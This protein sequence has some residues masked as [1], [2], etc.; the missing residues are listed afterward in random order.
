MQRDE[1]MI[2]TK[3]VSYFAAAM[4]NYKKGF[5][6]F[7]AVLIAAMMIQPFISMFGPKMMID[8]IVRKAVIINI[9]KIA[10]VMILADFAVKLITTFINEELDK[11]YYTGLDRHLEAAVGKKSME[12]KFETTENKET[13]D[14]LADARTGID[15]GYSGGSKGLFNSLAILIVNSVVLMLSVFVVCRYSFIPL[16]LVVVNVSLNAFFESRLNTIKIEQIQQLAVTDRA[17]HYLLHGLSD[18]RYGKDIRL[19]NAKDMM[20]GRVDEFN[21]KQSEINKTQAKKAQKYLTGSKINQAVT[22]SLT[23]LLLAMMVAEKKI[24][25]GDFTM[26]VAAVTTIVSAINL[27]LKQILELKKF[28]GYSDKF[29]RYVEGNVYEEK[30]D[31]KTD[32]A[33]GIEIEFKNVY[34]KYPGSMEYALKNINAVIRSGERW[35]VVGLNGAGK[36]TFIKLICR[37]Y[38]C[39]KGEILLNGVNIMDYEYSSYMKT[40]SAVF[41]DFC[42]L[43][44]SIKENIICDRPDKAEDSELTSLLEEVG[45][46][47]KVDSLPQGLMTPVFRYYDQSGFEPSGGEQQKIAMARALYKDAPVLILDEPT[48]ALDP[49]AEREIYE[50]FNS[51]VKNKTAIFI[52]HRLASCR[53]CDKLLVFKD[54]EIVERGTHQSLLKLKDGLYAKMYKT[55]EKMYK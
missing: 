51:M 14:A 4:E 12:L 39:T 48:A 33:D 9:I 38:E 13:L 23:Y 44:F 17:Y 46:K 5:Y 41:Q 32:I 34:F 55:Q 1:K 50:Q 37:L 24:G 16:A 21:D 36:S 15:S 40:I 43:N 45:L 35:S 6:I 11:E 20:L 54:G 29:I 18:I 2:K 53:F 10:A 19:F 42:L 27:V 52:S 26:L 30:G 47:D 7:Y 25:I 49:I 3:P 22:A 31:K 28:C 8:A